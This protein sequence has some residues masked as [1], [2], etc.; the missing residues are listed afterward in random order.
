MQPT[1][2]MSPTLNFVTPEPTEVT[3]PT[4]SWPG[5]HGY[6]VGITPLHSFRTWCKSEWQMPQN[7]ISICTSVSVGS[8][9]AVVEDASGDV[10]LAA[11]KAFALYMASTL[12]CA[13][14]SLICK[15]CQPP[16]KTR[17]QLR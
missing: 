2:A 17:H 10:A 12:R 6:T 7:K 5:T 3:R 4:I 11:E 15:T 1:A 8:R 9:R 16:C 13:C 14:P